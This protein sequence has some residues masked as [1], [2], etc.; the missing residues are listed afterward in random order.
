M[1][2]AIITYY[3]HGLF[4]R[5]IAFEID[6]QDYLSGKGNMLKANNE[7][8]DICRKAGWDGQIEEENRLIDAKGFVNL[9]NGAE[10]HLHV[11]QLHKRE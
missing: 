6:Q 2:V 4:I 10:V 3:K 1:L 11:T 8:V 9:V 7:F 5:C